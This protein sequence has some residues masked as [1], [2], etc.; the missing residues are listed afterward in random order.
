MNCHK[1]GYVLPDIAKFCRSC[2]EAQIKVAETF[3]S[4]IELNNREALIAIEKKELE[5]ARKEAELAAEKIEHEKI[6]ELKRLEQRHNQEI[7]EAKAESERL[8]TEQNQSAQLIKKFE[9]DRVN[10]EISKREVEL[11]IQKKE[12]EKLIELERLEQRHAQEIASSKAQA[13]RLLA[14]QNQSAQLIKQLEADRINLENAKKEAEL[15]AEKK[16]QERLFEVKRL[17]EQHAQEISLTKVESE[18]LLAE[19]DQSIQLIKQLEQEKEETKRQFE[20]SRSKKKKTLLIA[21]FVIVVSSGSA[22][23]AY[24]NYEQIEKALS[25]PK[26]HTPINQTKAVEPKKAEP[27]K[28]DVEVIKEKDESHVKDDSIK[29]NEAPAKEDIKK[30]E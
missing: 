5:I 23:Y 20:I 10:L 8:L 29:V 4:N 17:E 30:S 2:G 1:C 3:G 15:A 16:E 22:Y 14:E 28:K 9:A 11:E 25:A 18:R 7:T 24:S 12:K 19:R 6:S 21:L 26:I 27:I 13:E